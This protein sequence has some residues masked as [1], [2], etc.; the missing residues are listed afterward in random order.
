MIR[1]LIPFILISFFYAD[2]H[3][4]Q[5]EFMGIDVAKVT[6]SYQDTIFTNHPVT[7]VKF[8]ANTETIGSFFYPVDNYYEIIHF[9]NK[10]NRIISSTEYEDAYRYYYLCNNQ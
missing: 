7:I 6:M 5:V 3:H 9:T 8:S 4:Y 10:N 2:T 1:V